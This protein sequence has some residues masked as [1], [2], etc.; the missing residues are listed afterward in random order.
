MKSIK[1]IKNISFTAVSLICI[2]LISSCS[3]SH[4]PGVSDNL[5]PNVNDHKKSNADLTQVLRN[6][7]QIRVMGNLQSAKITINNNIRFF[8]NEAPLFIVDGKEMGYD[9]PFIYRM[10]KGSDVRKIR[11]MND[12]E[13]LSTYGSRGR[14]GVVIIKTLDS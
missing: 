6:V 11:V 1:R 10:V 2:V 4:L 8:N 14:N 5:L 9:Y 12:A 7:P 13:A 3:T